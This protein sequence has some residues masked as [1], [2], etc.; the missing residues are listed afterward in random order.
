MVIDGGTIPDSKLDHEIV[1]DCRGLAHLYI[2]EPDNGIYD[3][4]NKGTALVTGDYLLYL[5]AGDILHP[6]FDFEK[7]SVL[8]SVEEPSMVWGDSW[9]KDHKGNTYKRNTRSKFWLRYGM[10]VCHQ[11]VLFKR[12]DLGNPAYDTSFRI[13]ADYDLVCRIYAKGLKIV[14][15]SIPIC[16]YDLVGESSIHKETTLREES[17]VRVNHFG[18]PSWFEKILISV[19]RNLWKFNTNFPK[20]RSVWRRW[21]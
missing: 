11:A 16:I 3:A 21:I 14:R 9:D 6:E 1:N 18:F 10:A 2:S 20:V 15:S 19:K 12:S 7:I 13:A 4:M 8:C 17:L 5:N